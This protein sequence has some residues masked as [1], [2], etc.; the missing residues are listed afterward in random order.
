MSCGP[1]N[2]HPSQTTS[3]RSVFFQSEFAATRK[4][5]GTARAKKDTPLPRTQLRTDG[6]TLSVHLE[7]LRLSCPGKHP[8][9]VSRWLHTHLFD[10]RR[11]SSGRRLFGGARI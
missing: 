9:E 4:K 5:H 1:A 8:S 7:L 10:D 2:H 3:P 11:I 6:R